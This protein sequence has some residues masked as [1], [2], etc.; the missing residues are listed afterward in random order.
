MTAGGTQLR[1]AKKRLL[2][3]ITP[4]TRSNFKVAQL[5][6]VSIQRA[7]LYK[8]GRHGDN[9]AR[10]K[11][12]GTNLKTPTKKEERKERKEGKSKKT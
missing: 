7:Q 8:R 1:T 2:I 12:L 5:C 10:G 3:E 4:I 6:R 9:R 11:K